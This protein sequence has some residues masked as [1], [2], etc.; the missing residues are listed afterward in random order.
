MLSSQQMME[1]LNTELLAQL[2]EAGGKGVERAVFSKPPA[3]LGQ[4]T[5]QR[6]PP[7]HPQ[8]PGTIVLHGLLASSFSAG[9]PHHIGTLLPR[10][11]LWPQLDQGSCGALE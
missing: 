3:P 1:E 6:D 2:K 9:H 8:P 7:A 11:L 5:E 10:W 4:G